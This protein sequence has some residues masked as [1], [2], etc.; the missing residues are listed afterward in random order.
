M[1]QFWLYIKQQR[2]FSTGVPPL[3]VSSCLVTE[4]NAKAEVLNS[5]FN[6]AFSKGKSCFADQFRQ[7][8]KKPGNRESQPP[9]GK[10][11]ITETGVEENLEMLNPGKAASSDGVSPRI[12]K[13]LSHEI[14]QQSLNTSEVP[15]DWRE[16]VVMPINCKKSEHY[17]PA[18]Y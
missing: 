5:Q 16:A 3:K 8:R 18:N 4:L 1:K 6:S 12:L 11:T 13:E 17:N 15:A 2:T 10:I 14:H 7:K 9:M